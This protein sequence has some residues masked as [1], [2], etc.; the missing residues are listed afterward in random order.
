MKLNNKGVVISTILFGTLAI[1]VLV[2][3]LMLGLLRHQAVL[4]K[5]VTTNIERDLNRCVMEEVE[6]EMC[7]YEGNSNCNR[8]AYD[9]CRGVV[10]ET[11]S[12]LADVVNVG[13]YVD[14]DAG[15]WMET[16]RKPNILTPYTLGGYIKNNSRNDSVS[17]LSTPMYNGW[18][19]LSVA[20]GV[21]TLVHAGTPEC[22]QFTYDGENEGVAY[23][24]ELI[25][26]GTASGTVNSEVE[27]IPHN[28]SN[29]IINRDYA[30][31]VSVL[32][33]DDLSGILDIDNLEDDDQIIHDVLAIG[34][35]YY[36]A[37]AVDENHLA[38]IYTSNGKTYISLATGTEEIS[39]TYG[40]RPIIKLRV[41]VE[42]TGRSEVNGI[43]TWILY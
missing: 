16:V 30:S 22:F 6:L 13:D 11:L 42:T 34:T 23:N 20:D 12:V 2:L 10:D 40:I 15:V 14:Y 29:Y 38:Y 21:V 31:S 41:G 1:L 17:C 43:E 32:T 7:Y 19:V 39:S 26:R 5:K 35:N 37:S 9:S 8:K 3:M 24:A 27:A 28:F 33:L 4:N 36:L 18:R 25:L